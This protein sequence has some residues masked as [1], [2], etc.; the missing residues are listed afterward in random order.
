VEIQFTRGF[1]VWS[2]SSSA[3]QMSVE[4]DN[5]K[6]KKSVTREY[7]IGDLG[8]LGRKPEWQGLEEDKCEHIT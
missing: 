1:G 3:V 4:Y 7:Q 5:E 2:G 6:T 8:L